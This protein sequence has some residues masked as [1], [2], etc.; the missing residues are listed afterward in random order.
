M[1]EL[2]H[3]I[4]NPTTD[5][6]ATLTLPWEKRIKSRQRVVLDN[7]EEA[8]LFLER[9]Q[10]LRNGDVVSSDDGYHVRIIAAR[11]H[12]STARAQTPRQLN[13]ACYHL[14]NRHVDLEI[15]DGFVRYPHDHVLDDMV[16]GLG[17]SIT[18]EQAPFEPE[19]GA[20][21]H[22]QHHHHHH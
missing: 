2:T 22:G 13:I 17:L 14:G 19:T 18:V 21:G 7:K 12:V 20:Y 6:P 3:K 11:E 1:I 4:K 5:E 9:G 8:G 10:I 16:K 15:R